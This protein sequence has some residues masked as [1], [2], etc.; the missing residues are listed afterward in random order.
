MNETALRPLKVC[1]LVQAWGPRSGGVKRYIRGKMDYMRTHP[2]LE[3]VLVIPGAEDLSRREG[4]SRIYEI[5]SLP[6]VGSQ[7]YRLLLNRSKMLEVIDREQP[8][9][10]EVG[11]AYRPAWVAVEAG[12]RSRIPVVAFYHSDFPR[13]LGS[14]LNEAVGLPLGEPVTRAVEHYLADLYNQMDAVLVATHRFQALLKEIGVERVV[15]LPLGVDTRVFRPQD[16]REAVLRELGLEKGVKLL[17]FV[18]RFADMKNLPVLLACLDELPGELGPFHLLL[19]GDGEK[20]NLVE[21][22]AAERSYVTWYPY[23]ADQN[24]LAEIYSAADLFVNPGTRETFGLV[25]VEAQACGTRVLG[26]RDGGMDETLAGEQPLIQAE[27]ATPEALAEAVARIAA[28]RDSDE[29]RLRRR[30]RIEATFSLE[31][32]FDRLISFYADLRQGRP[33]DPWF[34]L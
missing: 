17:L 15:R 19:V 33:L 6:I 20:R 16:S 12:E 7:G 30:E 13:A 9:V 22:A 34:S 25:S 1:D 11:N 26:V 10:L 23:V 4:G 21:R 29:D 24:R 14:K 28:L 3:H 31:R 27:E 2:S 32:T 18:G 5:A 8:D